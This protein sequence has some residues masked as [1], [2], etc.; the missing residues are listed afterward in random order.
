MIDKNLKKFTRISEIHKGSKNKQ[1]PKN[2]GKIL[3]K[4][5]KTQQSLESLKISK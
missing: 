5:K 1:L 4:P 3:E 2:L